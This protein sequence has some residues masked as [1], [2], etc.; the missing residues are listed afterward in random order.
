M[1][2]NEK[3]QLIALI[4]DDLQAHYVELNSGRTYSAESAIEDYGLD[5]LQALELYLRLTDRLG[6]PDGALVLE[7]TDTV[8]RIADKV[9][10]IQKQTRG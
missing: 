1:A 9:L 10:S 5:S 4:A 2:A 8:A 3:E 6:L 7:K